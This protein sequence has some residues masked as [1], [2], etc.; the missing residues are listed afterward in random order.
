MERSKRTRPAALLAAAIA[1]PSAVA[2]YVVAMVATMKFVPRHAENAR[3]VVS[4]PWETYAWLP[5]LGAFVILAGASVIFRKW[6]TRLTFL[7]VACLLV[8]LIAG[9]AN[10]L[11]RRDFIGKF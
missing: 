8:L 6:P 9:F 7:L 4:L 5:A 11:L 1:V 10:N 2:A 3:R